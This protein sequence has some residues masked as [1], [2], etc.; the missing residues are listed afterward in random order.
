MISTSLASS[1]I[2]FL[3]S[4]G[5]SVKIYEVSD[6]TNNS[7]VEETLVCKTTGCCPQLSSRCRENKSFVLGPTAVDRR[8]PSKIV[9]YVDASTIYRVITSSNES[10]TNF[11]F[12]SMGEQAKAIAFDDNH[13]MAFIFCGNTM[14]AYSFN[15]QTNRSNPILLK[16][17]PSIAIEQ[18]VRI[19]EGVL[20][21]RTQEATLLL[22]NINTGSHCYV[23]EGI[24]HLPCNTSE[25]GSIQVTGMAHIKKGYLLALGPKQ[26]LIHLK[27][28]GQ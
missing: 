1:T 13:T 7:T 14:N 24:T 16:G 2:R 8:S 28:D 9:Y 26:E 21:C 10:A 12:D 20:L 17:N 23:H 18:I 19:D 11:T 5:E 15:I 6:H 22:L 27:Y 25:H 4:D 3:V